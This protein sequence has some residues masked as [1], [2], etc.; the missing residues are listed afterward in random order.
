M[1]E[2]MPATREILRSLATRTSQDMRA[3]A[4]DGDELTVRALRGMSS[5]IVQSCAEIEEATAAV[6]R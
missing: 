5:L 4:R 3:A 6:R 1:S 2:T